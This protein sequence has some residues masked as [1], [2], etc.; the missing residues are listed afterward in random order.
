MNDRVTLEQG[1]QDNCATP[2][3]RVGIN[4]N[5][6]Y[7]IACSSEIGS[8]PVGRELW[9][10]PI[11]LFR[12]SNGRLGALEDRC[13]HRFVRLSH[14][15]LITGDEDSLECAYHGWRFDA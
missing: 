9:H 11:V 13:A 15:R 12:T 6:W 3:R 8:R 4:R 10:K 1:C 7:P 5:L 2:I 14:G